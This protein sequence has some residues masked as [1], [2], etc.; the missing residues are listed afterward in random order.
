M[1]IVNS[2]L[3][4]MVLLATLVML[5]GCQAGAD[6][7]A[8]APGK[9]IPTY[10]GKLGTHKGWLPVEEAARFDLIIGEWAHATVHSSE[11]GNTWQTLKHYN[12]NLIVMIFQSTPS[13]YTTSGW[14]ELGEG[15]DWVTEHHGIGSEDRWT[16]VGAQYGG[17]LQG[18]AYPVQR[19]MN[20]RNRRVRTGSARTAPGTRCPGRATGT[21]RAIPISQ[22]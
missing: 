13:T 19:L 4:M 14:G 3:P 2:F 15:R 17:Y 8:I 5:T 9:F 22:T 10:Y 21:L 12:P 16:A 6:Q 11:H 20:L 1:R 7:E 18:R